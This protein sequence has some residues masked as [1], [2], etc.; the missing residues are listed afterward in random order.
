LHVGWLGLSAL[1]I[2]IWLLLSTTPASAIRLS[3][4][5][6]KRLVLGVSVLLAVAAVAWL[7]PVLSSE[8]LRYRYD[9]RAWLLWINPYTVSPDEVAT[10]AASSQ[11]PEFRP[12]ELDLAAPHPQRT[13]LNLPVSQVGFLATRTLEYLSPADAHAAELALPYADSPSTR[14]QAAPRDWRWLLLQLPWWRQL[15]FWRCLLAAVFLLV[16]GELVAWLRYREISP[17]WAVVFAWQP[18]VVLESLGAAHQD[19]IGV[20]FLVAGLRRADAGNMRRAAM[21]LAASVAVKPLALLV[22]PFVIRRAWRMDGAEDYP[23]KRMEAPPSSAAAARRLIGWFVLTLGLLGLPLYS[24]EALSDFGRA[25]HGYLFG[26]GENAALSRVLEAMFAGPDASLERMARV[27]LA[28]WVICA[29]AVLLAAVIAWQR[30]V[31]PGAALYGMLMTMLLLGPVAAPWL[32]IWPLA[33]VP[34]L[35]G[36]TGPAVLAWSGTAALYYAP[37]TL[38]GEALPRALLAWQFAPIYVLAALEAVSAGRR[39]L[40]GRSARAATEISPATR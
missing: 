12:D 13:T 14:A 31:S 39:S 29:T 32:L 21:C 2:S 35:R 20:L 28:S 16:V 34:T 9:G 6:S 10:L 15:F 40:R 25:T 38:A 26:T 1:S 18:L 23:A 7:R 17:W 30:R 33:L 19:I 8:V 3:P 4:R 37:E 27:R 11:D 5:L 24:L 22:L 36:R